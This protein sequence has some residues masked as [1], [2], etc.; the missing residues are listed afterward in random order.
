MFTLHNK[1]YL[2][3]VDYNSKFPIITMMED[4]ST[5]SLI[6]SWKIIFFRIWLMKKIM[7]DAGGNFISDKFKTFCKN[8]HIEQ[9]VSS[10]HHHQSNGQVAACIIVI[11]WTLKKCFNIKPNPQ[12]ALYQIISCAAEKI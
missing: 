6:L 4:L 8:L 10:S 5:D 2:C 11:K 7:S 3:I 1:N 9:P 12:T